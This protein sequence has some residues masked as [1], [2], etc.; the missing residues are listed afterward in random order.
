LP[1]ALW[2]PFALA[3]LLMAGAVSPALALHVVSPAPGTTVT[4]GQE[5]TLRVALDGESVT[6]VGVLSDGVAV[7]AT[8]SGGTFEAPV[9]VPREA[10]GG[11]VLVGYAVLAGGGSVF[12][13]VN[14]VAD[15]G[16][17]R[18]LFVSAMDRLTFAGQVVPV[19]VKGLFADGVVR[20]LRAP[21]LGTTYTSSAP[22][23]VAADPTGLVQARSNG[24]ATVQVSSRG[25]TASVRVQ[26]AIPQGAS[27][28]IP[29]LDVGPDQNVGA[30]QLVTLEAVATDADGDALEYIWEQVGG[31]VVTLRNVRAAQP[32]FV[33]PRSTTEQLLEFLVSV[34]DA[35]GATT[36]PRL[37]RVTVSPAVPV[38]N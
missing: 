18:S 8:V 9:R 7:P 6:E 15:P 37:V 30:E 34:R 5:V 10:V 24:T 19:D 29:T 2:L 16:P 23:V 12:A 26:V 31:R 21:D 33:S 32:V 20:D 22:G 13:R 14:V 3:G 28:A 17:L 35:K 4:P 36:L 27:N 25:R 38:G 11:D 1:F